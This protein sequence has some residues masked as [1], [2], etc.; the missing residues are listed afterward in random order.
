VRGGL[1]VPSQRIRPKSRG[2]GFT[3]AD[4]LQGVGWL[5]AASLTRADNEAQVYLREP[6]MIASYTRKANIAAAIFLAALVGDIVLLSTGHRDL[7][8]NDVFAL[9]FGL[10][11]ASYLYAMWAYVKAKGRSGA[12]ALMACWMLIGPIVILLLK[13]HSKEGAPAAPA[14]PAQGT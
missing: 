10:W 7:R 3:A 11:A 6:N 8:D 4:Y 5:T 2:I 9:A 12:W 1:A 13:D 14:A